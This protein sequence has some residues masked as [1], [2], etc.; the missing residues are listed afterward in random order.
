MFFAVA[1]KKHQ[2][3]GLRNAEYQ[4]VDIVHELYIHCKCLISA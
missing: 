2:V 4:Y 1:Y 3:R